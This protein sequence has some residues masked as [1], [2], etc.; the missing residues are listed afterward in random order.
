[1]PPTLRPS[2][3]CDVVPHCGPA[4]PAAAGWE[5]GWAARGPAQQ[6]P[7][8]ARTR[9]GLGMSTSVRLR[10]G[11]WS[12]NEQKA[13]SPV[14]GTGTQRRR[15]RSCGHMHGLAAASHQS[16]FRKNENTQPPRAQNPRH[17]VLGLALL[18]MRSSYAEATP[19]HLTVTCRSGSHMVHQNCARCALGAWACCSGTVSPIPTEEPPGFVLVLR[20]GQVA[21]G[22]SSGH[23][24]PAL[25]LVLLLLHIWA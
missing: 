18:G 17:T 20:L 9:L 7:P 24:A 10:G 1:M 14:S 25:A 23:P 5:A 15:S 21:G 11:G 19:S 8:P 16:T 22:Q 2:R 4:A 3:G 6:W 12:K 13:K